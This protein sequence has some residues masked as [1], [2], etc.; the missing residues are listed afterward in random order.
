MVRSVQLSE[1]CQQHAA[2]VRWHGR[3]VQMRRSRM[4]LEQQAVPPAVPGDDGWGEQLMAGPYTSMAAASMVAARAATLARALLCAALFVSCST[5][6]PARP[7]FTG[8][9]TLS[10]TW[11]TA[12]QAG[13]GT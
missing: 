12:G 11:T 8:S 13:R 7:R 10:I 4:K 3:R 6:G 5:A 1:R 2:A 9:S